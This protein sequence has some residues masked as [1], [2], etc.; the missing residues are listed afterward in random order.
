LLDDLEINQDLLKINC[1]SISVIYSAKNQVYHSRTKH[2]DVRFQFVREILDEGDIELQKI[3]MKENPDDML[4]KIVSRVNL[5][6]AK[7]YSISFHLCELSGARLDELRVALS[8]WVRRQ[9]QWCSQIRVDM[10]L[11]CVRLRFEKSSPMW[12]I[13]E[14]E[15]KILLIK[16]FLS[17]V[18]S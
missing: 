10:L 13:V 11:C 4:N 18:E 6:V 3:H 9:P 17:S 2:I 15:G 14:R 1:D 12:R 5:N 16:F 8:H 7:N